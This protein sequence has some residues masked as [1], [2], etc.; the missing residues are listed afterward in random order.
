MKE[1]NRLG[2][3]SGQ[4]FYNY[5]K[6][7]PQ[8]TLL[9]DGIIDI[10]QRNRITERLFKSY[11]TTMFETVEKGILNQKEMEYIVMEY[12]GIEKSPFELAKEIGFTD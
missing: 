5:S 3:K 1:T 2:I 6:V 12:M 7:P 4:G 11:L 10:S 9:K 8:K